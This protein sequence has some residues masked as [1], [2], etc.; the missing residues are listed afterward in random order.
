VSVEEQ[1][2]VIGE[3]REAQTLEWGEDRVLRLLKDPANVERLQRERVALEIARAGG[4]PV[5][6]DFGPLTVAGR[7]GCILER[8]HGPTTLDLLTR[9]P[10]RILQIARTLG[11][12]H[13]RIHG[14]TAGERLPSVHDRIQEAIAANDALPG[15]T[16]RAAL[17]RLEALDGGEALCHW[18]YQPANVLLPQSGPVV[19]DWTFAARGHPA[20]DVA[21]TQLILHIG[22]RPDAP[23]VASL[24]D[25]LGRQI[26]TN[27]YLR[28]Y[29]RA[30]P[31]E[32]HLVQLWLPL[33]ALP[34]LAAGIVSER[35]RLLEIV[36][37]L[38]QQ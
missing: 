21:R 11:T 33:V 5:P 34:R 17:E 30:R 12:T 7:P 3:G 6:R 25:R 23:L 14:I 24:V 20:A 27:R 19:I 15:D 28:A 4:A 2:R 29:R 31:V 35:E 13:A 1:H 8:I 9:S 22:E 37:T 36:N 16:R 38:S 18:D 32:Q 10:W 26:L